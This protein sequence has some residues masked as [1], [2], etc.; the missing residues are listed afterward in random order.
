[1]ASLLKH[2]QLC[3]KFQLEVEVEGPGVSFHQKVGYIPI[4][5]TFPLFKLDETEWYHLT[6]P[7]DFPGIVKIDDDEAKYTVKVTAHT[8]GDADPFEFTGLGASHEMSGSVLRSHLH[9]LLKVYAFYAASEY[10]K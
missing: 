8:P 6:T 9:R 5:G 10:E 1:M 2:A 4:A 3:K 7:R